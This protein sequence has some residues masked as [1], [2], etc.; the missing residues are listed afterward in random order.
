MLNILFNKFYLTL[1]PR[2]NGRHLPDDIFKCIFLNENVWISLKIS[3]KFVSKVPIN[4][5]PALVLIMAWGRP[6]DKPLSEPMMVSL[7]THIC[8]TRHQWVKDVCKMLAILFRP[9]Y[10]NSLRPCDIYIYIYASVQHTN[11]TSDDGLAP[12]WCQAIIWT[13][14]AIL[15]IR[16]QG[17]HFSEILSIVKSFH[18]KKCTWKCH[19][20]NGSHFVLFS[21]C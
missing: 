4:N 18:S 3:L 15:S 20:R 19:L 13:N 6:G 9:Q 17:T 21:V 11:I 7:P 5:I 14:A 10:F 2:Q 12:V 8:V 16:H 1:R